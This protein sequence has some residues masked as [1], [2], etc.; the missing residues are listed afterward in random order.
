MADSFPTGWQHFLAGGLV[1]GVGVSLMF[2][3]SGR[4]VGLSSFFSSTWS[5]FSG[6]SHFQRDDLVQSRVW[7]LWVAIGLVLGAALWWW[8]TGQ[9]AA[10]H[11]SVSPV[12]LFVGGV[13]AGFGARLSNGCT[14][15]HGICGL[16]SMSPAALV[17]VLVFMGFAMLTANLVAWLSGG[18]V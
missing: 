8:S 14:S 10:L 3:L 16:S 9:E 18:G 13:L 7:R 12:M 2:V 1:I 6:L 5:W 15:G 11:T 17:A 4:V